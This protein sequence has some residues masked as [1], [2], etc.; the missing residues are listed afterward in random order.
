MIKKTTKK[1]SQEKH[2][3]LKV[4]AELYIFNTEDFEYIANPETTADEAQRRLTTRRQGDYMFPGA[5]NA[6]KDFMKDYRVRKSP[7]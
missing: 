6:F 4:G 3:I 7:A 5:L 1:I 2:E